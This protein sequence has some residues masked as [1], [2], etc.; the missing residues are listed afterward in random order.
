M[1]QTDVQ[2]AKRVLVIQ[3]IT[4]LAFAAVMLVFGKHSA[5]SAVIG[6]TICTMANGVF[7]L[8]ALRSYRAQQPGLIVM[9]FYGAELLKI[10]LVLILFVA[11][12]K[13]YS[14]LILPALLGAY[15]VVQV[16]PALLASQLD[17]TKNT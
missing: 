1:R 7:A 5:L 10:G 2:Q 15:F 17:A 9:R 12:Y 16:L 3:L 4:T 11:V 14:G 8:R 6:G 13:F